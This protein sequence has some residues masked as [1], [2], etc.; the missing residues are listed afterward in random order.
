MQRRYLATDS[1][2][3]VRLGR[4]FA[5]FD[6]GTFGSLIDAGQFV[7]TL[8]TRQGVKVCCPEEIAFMQ[9]FISADHLL[10]QAISLE[11]SGYGNYLFNLLESAQIRPKRV[12][13]C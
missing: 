1:L 3:V 7:E 2:N 6:T 10:E 13:G 5:W 8:E 12:S 11:K 9:G 4:G